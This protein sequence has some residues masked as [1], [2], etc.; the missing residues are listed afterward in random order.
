MKKIKIFTLADHRPDLIE[1]QNNSI[2]KYV[3]D[4]NWEHIVLNNAINSNDH[5]RNS[6]GKPAN[7]LERNQLIKEICRSVGSTNIDIKLEEKFRITN[8]NV[9][10]TDTVYK[11]GITATSYALNWTW[12]NFITEEY[13][14]CIN[15]IIDSDMFFMN[16][17]NINDLMRNHNFAFIPQYRGDAQEVFYA[18]NGIIF[19]KPDQIINPKEFDFDWGTILG[20]RTD[21]GGYSHFYFEKYKNQLKILFLEFWNLGNLVY[22]NDE[23]K[24]EMCHLNGN[25]RFDFSMKN[26]EIIK[27]EKNKEKL[28]EIYD[29]KT[30]YYEEERENYQRY[31]VDKIIGI[32]EILAKKQ[33]FLPDPIWVDFI[34]VYNKDINESFIFHYKS[35]SNYQP[36]ATEEYNLQKTKELK[37]IL[38]V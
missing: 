2:K 28:N 31:L 8:N 25:L 33:I 35:G 36:F 18:W 15:V 16:D 9:N 10:F 37:K 13:K 11:D 27:F 5:V 26:N 22:Q 29:K 1:I 20:Q 6:K 32:K 21:I 38:G 14:N 12:D 34:N 17:I 4:E 30:F 19:V 23:E 3:K 7:V 24:Y